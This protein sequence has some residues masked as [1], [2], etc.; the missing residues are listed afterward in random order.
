MLKFFRKIRQNLLAAGNT[1]KYFKYAVGEIFLVVIGILIALSINNW[2][3]NRKSKIFAREIYTNL[4]TSLQQDSAE[5]NHIIELQTRSVGTLRRLISNDSIAT[6]LDR[7]E[8]HPDS[9]SKNIM[10]GVMSFFPKIGIYNLIVSSNGMDVLESKEVKSALINL[11]DYQYKQYENLDA[12]IDHKYHYQI[13]PVTRKKM[14]F[15]VEYD[16]DFQFVKPVNQE[17]FKKHFPELI[18]ECKDTYGVLSTGRGYLIQIQK[19]INE[20]I[21][22]IRTE[23]DHK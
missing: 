15:I 18:D 7:E 19:S 21:L 13:G 16:P 20:L 4:L 3:E 9:L 14:G 1:G 12:V 2:N 23:L 8:N 5:V 17:L 11:Y 22:L 6:Q 10:L